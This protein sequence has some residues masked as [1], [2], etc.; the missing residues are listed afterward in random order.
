M[1]SAHDRDLEDD[2]DT[3]TLLPTA[4]TTATTPPTSTKKKGT[5]TASASEDIPLTVVVVEGAS[6]QTP[7]EDNHNN[8]TTNNHDTTTTTT[9]RS[10][11]RPTKHHSVREQCLSCDEHHGATGDSDSDGNENIPLDPHSTTT[12]ATANAITTGEIHPCLREFVSKKVDTTATSTHARTGMTRRARRH[13]REYHTK[14]NELIDDFVHLHEH[15]NV[16]LPPHDEDD[17]L[18][19]LS[20]IRNSEQAATWSLVVNVLLLVV[21]AVAAAMSGSLAIISTVVESAMDLFSGLV[22]YMVRH[23][24]VQG[25]EA[26]THTHTH[27]HTN[28][29][30]HTHTH[31]AYP[32]INPLTPMPGIQT[33]DAPQPCIPSGQEAV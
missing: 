23:G 13:V 24:G 11:A 21:K 15:P 3:A 27:A 28:T 16:P 33:H 5:S 20:C 26:Y 4:T 9:E 8:N 22:F 6:D 14:Q 17:Q 2:S 25:G 29:H 1:S 7:S 30:T 32:P 12:T 19:S 18:G 10:A 31:T